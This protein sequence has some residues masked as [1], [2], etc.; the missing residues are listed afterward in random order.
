MEDL[1][2]AFEAINGKRP[3]HEKKWQYYDGIQPLVYS[4]NRLKEV[5]KGINA[6]FNQNWCAV[7]VDSVL[8]RLT[9]SGF[10]IAENTTAQLG[11]DEYWKANHMELDADDVHTACQVTGEAFIIADKIDNVLETYYNDP[12]LCAMFYK[13]DNPKQ[14]EFA[15]KW[16]VSD[17]GKN[18]MVLYYPDRIEKY[19]SDKNP[20]IWTSFT[21]DGEESITPNDFGKIPVFHFR[22]ERRVIKS[23]IND[24][25]TIQDAVNK[26][27]SDMMVAAEFGAY[28]QRWAITNADIK[29]MKSRPGTIQA[30][31]PG[32][33]DE[34]DTEVGEFSATDIGMYL[35]GID[36][37]AK[38]LSIITRIPKSYIMDSGAGVSG[39]ALVAMEAPLVKKAKS[40][41][42]AYSVTWNEVA[43]FILDN[44]GVAINE[45]DLNTRWDVVDSS[46]PFAQ[47]Q[48]LK[49]NWDAG[50]PVI[51]QL[52][53]AGWD[54][55][56]IEQMLVDIKDA[57]SRDK[58]LSTLLLEQARIDSEQDNNVT[59]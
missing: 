25:I 48:T 46:Q 34:Q 51:T 49:M 35:D 6:R 15:A 53:R 52:R 40:Y 19:V 12:R 47:A 43:T 9:L 17:N 50:I 13:S 56:E 28:K 39:D 23:A 33:S 14:K 20:S 58:V 54:E 42:S 37:L 22:N 29:T 24:A 3:Y 32:D 59:E 38:S 44:S 55:A 57:K 30:F 27:F 26:L 18:Y 1:Q 10:T 4:T 7:V 8:D 2:R 41:Q 21:P 45:Y 36:R 5:F 11:I 31:P 16:W